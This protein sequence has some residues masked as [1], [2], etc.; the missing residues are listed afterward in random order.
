MH[1]WCTGDAAVKECKEKNSWS[2]LHLLSLSRSF[3]PSFFY[4]CSFAG[5]EFS[6]DSHFNCQLSTTHTHLSHLFLTTCCLCDGWRRRKTR[7]M[8]QMCIPTVRMLKCIF[9]ILLLLFSTLIP[10]KE[11]E[12]YHGLYLYSYLFFPCCV[13]GKGACTCVVCSKLDAPADGHSLG[14]IVLLVSLSTLKSGLCKGKSLYETWVFV[15]ALK[16]AL[17]VVGL[18]LH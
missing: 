3:P 13:Q 12:C 18:R 10:R 7:K 17:T 16:L 9:Y 1:W 6:P 4:S 2:Q 8:K 15:G 14:P 5:A 11:E